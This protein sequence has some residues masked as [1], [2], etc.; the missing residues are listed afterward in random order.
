L[1]QYKEAAEYLNKGLSLAEKIDDKEGIKVACLS[2][3][4]L[5]AQTGDFKNAFIFNRRYTVTKDSIVN[6]QN[7]NQISEIQTK[8]ETDKRDKEIEFLNKDKQLQESIIEKQNIQRIAFLA[9]IVLLLGF[10]IFIFSS[11][12]RKQRDNKIIITQKE[13]VEKQKK[14]VDDKQK[15][16]IDSIHY[17][18]RIQQAMLTS[19]KYFIKNIDRLKKKDQL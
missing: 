8:Y 6:N 4:E 12:K 7:Q 14:L 1:H 16:I 2:L 18:K 3:S 9:G 19:E 17:A 11:F 15:E 10:S 5:Y 13:E